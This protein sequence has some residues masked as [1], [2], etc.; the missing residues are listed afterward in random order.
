MSASSLRW[1]LAAAIGVSLI[2]GAEH[3]AVHVLG[4]PLPAAFAAGTLA[5]AAAMLAA[6]LGWRD[7][8]RV[9]AR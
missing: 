5:G 1:V 7:R 9:S 2:W 3:A 4:W 6:A 8:R